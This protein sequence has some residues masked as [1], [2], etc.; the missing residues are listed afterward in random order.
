MR[1][2]STVPILLVKE[3]LAEERAIHPHDIR[4][5]CWQPASQQIP[6]EVSRRGTGR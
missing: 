3:R 1:R 5:S 2:S 6:G 4:V